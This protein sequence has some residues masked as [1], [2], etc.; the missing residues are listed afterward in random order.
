MDELL[1]SD[2][3][4]F[5]LYAE[6]GQLPNHTQLVAQAQLDKADQH[7]RQKIR[8]LFERIEANSETHF[9][10]Y[11]GVKVRLHKWQS[12]KSEYLEDK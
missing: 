10:S 9:H 6:S 11:Y 5:E 3:E 1:L 7:Y 2:E 8:E 4:L 12:L